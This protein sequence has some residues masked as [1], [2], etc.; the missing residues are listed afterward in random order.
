MN[1]FTII[2]ISASWRTSWFG[3]A[4]Q[5]KFI[6]ASQVDNSFV[7]YTTSIISSS[8]DEKWIINKPI[9]INSAKEILSMDIINVLLQS[10]NRSQDIDKLIDMISLSISNLQEQKNTYSTQAQTYLAKYEEC[11]SIKSTSDTNFYQEIN[12]WN[13]QKAF[14]FATESAE[15]AKCIWSNR[16]SYNALTQIINTIDSYISGLQ[17][18]KLVIQTNYN[19]IISNAQT[20]D[21]A[22]INKLQATINDLNATT[23]WID[24]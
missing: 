4:E 17:S 7:E 8:N 6:S 3:W 24:W 19:T 16:V 13:M 2:L 23:L 9:S 14:D 21:Q 18:K 10:T 20:L 11:K 5:N 12:N 22:T 1:W 15:S